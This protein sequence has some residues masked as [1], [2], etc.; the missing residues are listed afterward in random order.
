[1]GNRHMGG[2]SQVLFPRNGLFPGV[3]SGLA[4]YGAVEHIEFPPGKGK[5]AS[6][7]GVVDGREVLGCRGRTF[8]SAES[9][10]SCQSV[11]MAASKEGTDMPNASNTLPA[12]FGNAAIQTMS[13]REIADLTGK[14]HRHVLRDI[15]AMFAGLELPIEG[16]VQTWTHPQNGQSYREFSLPKD[17]TLTLV[18]GYNVKLR[19]AIIDR[20]QQL[21][22][23]VATKAVSASNQGAGREARLSFKQNLQIAKLA[24][25]EGNQALL[26]ANRAT[27]AMTGIDTLAL[28]GAVQLP[29]P[30]NDALLTP[31]EIGR[32]A[33]VG[34][35]RAVNQMLCGMGLQHA[36]RDA[37][38]HIYYELTDAGQQ[39]GGKML[40][41]G[42]KHGTG[43]PI[44]QLKWPSSIL[45][46]IQEGAA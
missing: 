10:T 38:G 17:L 23:E 29:A 25:L 15:E 16:Y 42:K 27:L 31:T 46:L 43:T 4:P 6:F 19:K 8:P 12:G 34:S 11:K 20:W 9:S 37:K 41:T 36:F 33:E 13:S 35:A 5:A 7:Q 30:D 44:R 21:E 32:R 26:A 1:M 2:Y 22:A 28:M 39:A 14:E 24:G 45:E 18:A 3:A 40:D